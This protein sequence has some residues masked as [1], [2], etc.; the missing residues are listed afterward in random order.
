MGRDRTPGA[1][2]GYRGLLETGELAGR[3]EQAIAALGRCTLCPRR[4]GVDRLAGERG[5]CRTGREALVASAVP[6]L[7]EEPC[8]SGSRGSGTVFFTH[9]NLT[10]VFCQNRDI[11]RGGRGDA[12]GADELAGLMLRLQAQG[13]H[14]INLVTPS[15]LAPQI[16]EAVL[17]AAREGLSV[18]LVWNSS[19]YDGLETL[20]L[21]DGAVDLYLPDFKYGSNETAARLSTAPD[22][23]D[24]ALEALRVMYRQVGDLELDPSGAAVRGLLVRHLVLPE[25]LAATRACLTFLREELSA[26]VGLSVMSQYTP[27]PGDSGESGLRR[28]LHPR[29]YARAVRWVEELGFDRA[30]V[31]HLASAGDWLPDFEED[32]PFRAS[33]P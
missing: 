27:F 18:P 25:D 14:N 31:Q 19:G 3:V 28:E 23:T 7:G 29:E 22:Y 21:L 4:C 24:R 20:R 26:S 13:C 30:Y 9:C 33:R 11:S 2:P 6:H 10:C 5:F 15:H 32:D 12:V 17:T 8:I 1:Y 16:L